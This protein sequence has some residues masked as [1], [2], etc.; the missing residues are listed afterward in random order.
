MAGLNGP[1]RRSLHCAPP[2]FLWSFVGVG[3]YHAPFFTEGRT[4]CLSNVACRKSGY[5][6]VGMTNLFGTKRGNR[7][8]STTLRFGRDDK[9]VWDARSRGNR[10]SLR[11]ATLRDGKF[12]WD[13]KGNSRSLRYA[14]VGMAV[15]FGT[16]EEIRSSS[17][18]LLARCGRRG[19]RSF[20]VRVQTLA[21]GCL[22]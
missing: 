7:R 5:A 16:K 15:L 8:S 2:D 6:S 13:E 18:S 10:R 1:N 14:S 19:P 4:R 17:R 11:Y 12:V 20:S 3:V 21:C 22:P 9:F